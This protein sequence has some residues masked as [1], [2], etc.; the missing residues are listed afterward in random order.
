MRVIGPPAPRTTRVQAPTSNVLTKGD[1]H[2]DSGYWE[3]DGTGDCD[4]DVV[5]ARVRRNFK[6]LDCVP[7]LRGTCFDG[8]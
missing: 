5:V 8:T 1:W 6:T 4:T 2:W 7:P 3:W